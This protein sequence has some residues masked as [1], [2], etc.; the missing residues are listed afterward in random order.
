MSKEIVWDHEE[1]ICIYTSSIRS[2]EKIKREKENKRNRTRKE[3]LR[4]RRF[5]YSHITMNYAMLLQKT[6]R[7]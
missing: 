4:K 2:E 5:V 3:V 1:D 7:K 6:K